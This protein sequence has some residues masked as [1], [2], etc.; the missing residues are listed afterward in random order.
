MLTLRLTKKMVILL[1]RTGDSQLHK[2]TRTVAEY[3]LGAVECRWIV[4]EALKHTL[5]A[6]LESPNQSQP[7]I[8]ETEL[9]LPAIIFQVTSQNTAICT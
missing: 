8:K 2:V 3:T 6:A 4:G 1:Q 7:Y 5:Q 9:P